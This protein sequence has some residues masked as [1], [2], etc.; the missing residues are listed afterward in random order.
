MTRFL[1]PSKIGLL[2]LVE[3]YTEAI[4]P[5]EATVPFLSFIL[6]QLFSATLRS[7]APFLKSEGND[8]PF[9]LDLESFETLLAPFSTPARTLVGRSLWDYFLQKLWDIDSVHALHEFFDRTSYLLV[10]TKE[11]LKRDSELDGRLGIPAPSDAMII[12]S[13]GSPLGS[14][15]RKAKVEFDRLR[16][17]DAITLW[18]SFVR[19]RQPSEQYWSRRPG[20]QKGWLADSVLAEGEEDWGPEAAETLELI[21]Y[22]GLGTEDRENGNICTDDIEKLLDLQVE[23]M[24]SKYCLSRSLTSSISNMPRTWA[25]NSNGGQRS[26]QE[27]CAWFQCSGTQPVSL[28]QVCLFSIFEGSI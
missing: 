8:L 28:S 14:F 22:G 10:K 21:A 18:S 7:H 26:I 25:S 2:V 27:C 20:V 17:C 16:F 4:V 19:W 15:V 9:I 12:L 6:K 3:L 13:R 11:E 1:I 23:Q 24:Q 5:T